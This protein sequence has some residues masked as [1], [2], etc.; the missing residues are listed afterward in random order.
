MRH[1][2]IWV[3]GTVLSAI[4]G[5]SLLIGTSPGLAQAPT[6]GELRKDQRQERRELKNYWRYHDGRWSHWD[7]ADR[8]WY[9][10]DGQHWYYN[11]GNRWNVY[12]F[13]K[14]FGREGFERGGYVVPGQT[15]TVV[16][17]THEVYVAPR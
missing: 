11:E 2:R 14:T 10:T 8:R 15:A 1:P 9:Y 3:F 5:V 7:A 6:P 16:V 4:L 12:R 13:D 17:P